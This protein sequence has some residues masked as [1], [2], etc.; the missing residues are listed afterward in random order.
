[1]TRVHIAIGVALV[2]I[3]Y[4]ACFLLEVEPP[5][6]SPWPRYLGLALVGGL[7]SLASELVGG[8]VTGNDQVGD[9]T[10]RR[11]GRLLVLFVLVG[12]AAGILWAV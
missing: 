11:A 5:R 12:V 6:H 8:F 1:M 10:L 9:P 3:A 2:C 4:G 7:V